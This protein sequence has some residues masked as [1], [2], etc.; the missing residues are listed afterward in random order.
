MFQPSKIEPH[1]RVVD[2]RLKAILAKLGLREEAANGDS[3][4][5]TGIPQSP[6]ANEPASKKNMPF[7]SEQ[8]AAVIAADPNVVACSVWTGWSG[9]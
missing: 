9:D 5:P 4:F 2:R 8:I 7:T 1:L 3:R 6:R